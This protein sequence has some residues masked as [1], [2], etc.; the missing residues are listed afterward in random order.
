MPATAMSAPA[1]LCQRRL[2][3][4]RH[5][6]KQGQQ[7]DEGEDYLGGSRSSFDQASRDQGEGDTEAE[8]AVQHAPDKRSTSRQLGPAQRDEAE[9]HQ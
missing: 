5:G 1:R 4:L 7:R 2:E 6:E 8:Q 9:E 3:V